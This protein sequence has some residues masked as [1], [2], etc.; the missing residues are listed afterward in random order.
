[1]VKHPGIAP[2]YQ[3]RSIAEVRN[4]FGER[5][6][7]EKLERDCSPTNLAEI[8]REFNSEVAIIVSKMTDDKSLPKAQRKKLQ[9]V[10]AAQKSDAAC[11]IKLVDKSSNVAVT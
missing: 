10:N 2:T 11:L 6:Q 9:I 5:G 1:L 3:S 8:E 7:L 4:A